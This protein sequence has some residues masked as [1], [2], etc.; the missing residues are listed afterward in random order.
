M[1][2]LIDNCVDLFVNVYAHFPLNGELT[3]LTLNKY[4]LFESQRIIY[5][6]FSCDVI[7]SSEACFDE[8]ALRLLSVDMPDLLFL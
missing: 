7:L 3:S 6:F 2:V 8:M 1:A 5:L 4:C